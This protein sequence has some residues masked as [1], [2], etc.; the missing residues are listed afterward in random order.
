MNPRVVIVS[1][2]QRPLPFTPLPFSSPV[3]GCATRLS[4]PFLFSLF[5][6]IFPSK[7]IVLWSCIYIFKSNDYISLLFFNIHIFAIYL[8]RNIY[9]HT[10]ENKHI[11]ISFF[12]FFYC[13]SPDVRLYLCKTFEVTLSLFFLEKSLLGHLSFGRRN[14]GEIN[15]NRYST[16]HKAKISLSKAERLESNF[17]SSCL[18][19]AW[20]LK[21]CTLLTRWPL[22]SLSTTSSALCS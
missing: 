9:V 10:F 12:S 13:E 20:F 7:A 21:M 1:L 17:F 15:F 14:E 2:V 16:M 22:T 5:L 18:K 3:H 11:I 19:T 6:T 8:N 4:S